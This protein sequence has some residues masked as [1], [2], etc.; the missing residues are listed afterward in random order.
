MNETK[1][2]DMSYTIAQIGFYLMSLGDISLYKDSEMHRNII[3]LLTTMAAT[4]NENMNKG[5]TKAVNNKETQLNTE[6]FLTKKEVIQAY[7][8][9][10]TE[11]GLTQAIHKQD[12]PY[13]KRGSR[14]FIKKS[15][16]E[17]WIENSSSKQDRSKKSYQYV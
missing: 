11:Y 1:F 16:I 7:Y 17:A 2:K 8:P 9:L 3:L 13:H 14:Y 5:L 4:L 6:Q 12:I 15:D 10:F